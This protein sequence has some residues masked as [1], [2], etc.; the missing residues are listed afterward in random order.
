[1]NFS[2]S[3][4][5]AQSFQN[6]SFSA[7]STSSLASKVQKAKN[8]ANQRVAKT[9]QSLNQNKSDSVN[10]ND[11]KSSKSFIKN[12]KLL[13]DPNYL[14]NFQVMSEKIHAVEW[15]ILIS[16]LV[17]GIFYILVPISNS[18]FFEQIYGNLMII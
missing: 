7:I 17:L 5:S 4:A 9:L 16:F 11:I 15:L 14:N 13:V 18:V 8:L 3:T 1:M 6:K 10:T 2:I 12:L